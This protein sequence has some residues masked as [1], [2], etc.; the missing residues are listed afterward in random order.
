[1]A[2]DVEVSAPDLLKVLSVP[3]RWAIVQ[4]LADEALCTCHLVDELGAAQPL[5]SHHL[6]V[7]KEAGIVHAEPAGSFT[8]YVLD[9]AVLAD[10]SATL[11]RLAGDGQPRTRRRP[12]A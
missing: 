7:L 2:V 9:R 12:C 4:R 10:L 1:M 6:R 3:L 11:D 5:I 8:Y